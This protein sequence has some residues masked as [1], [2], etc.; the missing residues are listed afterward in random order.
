M[1]GDVADRGTDDGD[2]RAVEADAWARAALFLCLRGI[3]YASLCGSSCFSCR[4]Y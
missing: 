1:A 3:V 2:R 4:V